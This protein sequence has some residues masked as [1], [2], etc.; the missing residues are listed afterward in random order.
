MD[1]NKVSKAIKSWN[2]WVQQK[3]NKK[4]KTSI[5]NLITNTQMTS[6]IKEKKKA[7]DSN[8]EVDSMTSIDL[9]FNTIIFYFVK[10]SD[11]SLAVSIYTPDR[12]N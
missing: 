7:N 4:L 1:R 6:N 10:T 5:A 9:F 3:D 2:F 8:I 12:L 11:I